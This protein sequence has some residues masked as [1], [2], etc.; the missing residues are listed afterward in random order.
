MTGVT[1]GGSLAPSEGRRAYGRLADQ[2]ASIDQSNDTSKERFYGKIKSLVENY[3]QVKDL[4]PSELH[5]FGVALHDAINNHEAG[6]S[7]GTAFNEGRV[8]YKAWHEAGRVATA[9]DLPEGDLGG[10]ERVGADC[11]NVTQ[12]A[13]SFREHKD[14]RNGDGSRLIP[15]GSVPTT[16]LYPTQENYVF[17]DTRGTVTRLL[18]ENLIAGFTVYNE[19]AKSQLR[20]ADVGEPRDIANLRDQAKHMRAFVTRPVYFD[21]EDIQSS[22]AVY[23]HEDKGGGWQVRKTH[24]KRAEDTNPLRQ[25]LEEKLSEPF[26]GNA[27]FYQTFSEHEKVNPRAQTWNEMIV[28]YRETGGTEEVV[29]GNE[30]PVL[31]SEVQDLRVRHN[32]FEEMKI[33]QGLHGYDADWASEDAQGARVL[34]TNR[35]TWT[36]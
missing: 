30:E 14:L 13:G 8:I 1:S 2:L 7:T 11:L 31:A 16:L 33:N 34:S 35:D 26:R 32:A 17:R 20:G 28:K 9:D 18:P 12:N 5:Q 6:D 3:N 21:K 24:T 15:I 25:T 29:K 27:V 22:P 36:E 19:A 10:K 4:S 23:T